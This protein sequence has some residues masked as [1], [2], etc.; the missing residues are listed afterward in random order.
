M[1]NDL[2]LF[3]L[4]NSS[5]NRSIKWKKYFSIYEKL[6]ESFRNKKITFVEIG[7]LDGGSLEIW[8]KYFGKDSRI[9]GIDKNPECKKLENENYEIFIGS[10]SDTNFWKQFY[11][12]IGNVDIVLDDGGHTN[13]QQ[14]TS[15]IESVKF[16]NNG[17]LHVVE[18]VHSSYQ[19]HYGN[20]FKYSFINFSKKTVDDINST[21]PNLKKFKYSL[22]KSIS[23]VEFFESIVAFKINRNLTYENI[24]IDNNGLTSNN[25]DMTI[26]EVFIKSRD[27]FKFL[28][29]FDIIK[30]IER[31]IIKIFYKNQSKKLKKFFE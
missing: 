5:N 29:K 14:I 22:S 26:D 20:P 13:H 6:F 30:K 4:F 15:L 2:T 7:I 8:K 18:D 24:L 11:Q 19:K 21:F 16:I 27:K 1:K 25:K 3:D 23:S 12:K 17:G 28:Y 31:I 10:Q 9:I